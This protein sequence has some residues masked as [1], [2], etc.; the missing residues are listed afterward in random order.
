MSKVVC[1]ESG[2]V[3]GFARMSNSPYW[4]QSFE[5]WDANGVMYR[6]SLILLGDSFERVVRELVAWDLENQPEDLE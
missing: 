3:I 1:A 6:N 2:R 4:S 5:A